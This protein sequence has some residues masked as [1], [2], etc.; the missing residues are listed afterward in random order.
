MNINLAELLSNDISNETAFHIASFV[1]HLAW[2]I[3][4]YY[5]S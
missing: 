3:S 5:R 1:N 4:T 2:A